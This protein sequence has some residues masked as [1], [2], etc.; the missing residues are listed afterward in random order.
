MRSGS[1]RSFTGSPTGTA[2]EHLPA[3][4]IG[5]SANDVAAARQ[6]GIPVIVVGWG[7]TAIPARELGG[8]ILIERFSEL[9]DALARLAVA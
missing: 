6:A 8:D 2:G 5:D 7:Y 3:V 9:P 1:R 4:M